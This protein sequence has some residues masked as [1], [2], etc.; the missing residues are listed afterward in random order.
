MRIKICGFTKEDDIISAVNS[1]V[2]AVGM[3]FYEKS[4]RFIS[5][6]RAVALKKEIPAFVNLV[7]LFV[8]ASKDKVKE[9]QDAIYPDYLQFHGDES[10]EVCASFKQKYIKAFRVGSPTLNSGDSLLNECL[11]YINA[12]GWLFDSYSC[13]YG[14][15]GKTFNHDLLKHICTKS[16]NKRPIILS[17]GLSI[18]NIIDSINYLHPWA[19]DIS[20]GVELE[21]G[22]KS[23]VK[24]RELINLVN[25]CS[26]N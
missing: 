8:N 9:V 16:I 15:S 13:G 25:S 10:P 1:G 2:D 14:G 20:S 22:I 18:D 24:I 4:K 17:G 7:A 21:P 5:I 19:I 11:N 6:D 3:V 23:I 26:Y 12:D